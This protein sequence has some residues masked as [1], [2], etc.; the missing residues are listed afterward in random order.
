MNLKMRLIIIAFSTIMLI[1]S[2][3]A[4]PS[5]S[6]FEFQL[7]KGLF[8]YL[9][10]PEQSQLT[11]YEVKDLIAFY[12]SVDDV[13]TVACNEIIG[14]ASGLAVSAILEKAKTI[15]REVIPTCTDGTLYGECSN[16]KPKFCY[17]GLLKFMCYGPDRI[18]GNKDDCGCP[19][20]YEFCESDGSCRLADISC[21]SEQDCGVSTYTGPT[22]CENNSVHRNYVQFTCN[23]PGSAESYCS[24]HNQTKLIEECSSQCS[25]GEC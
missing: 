18:I 6:E 23:N 20:E 2:V 15:P 14:A 10:N 3:L 13:G 16:T 8:H 9:S 5:E 1:C 24:Y 19:E 17:S 7:K 12:L 25:E 22:F 21:F 11:I 4:C